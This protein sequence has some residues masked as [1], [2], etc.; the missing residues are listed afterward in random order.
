MRFKIDRAQDTKKSLKPYIVSDTKMY[1]HDE[2]ELI[3]IDG[4]KNYWVDKYYNP[5]TGL[6][7][8]LW[9]DNSITSSS[10][11]VETSNKLYAI[12]EMEP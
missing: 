2:V 11:P 5:L 6:S 9:K 4:G 7:F 3:F 8:I 12:G 1:S 10:S